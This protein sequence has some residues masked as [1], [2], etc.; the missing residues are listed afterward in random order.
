[1]IHR[2]SAFRDTHW[3]CSPATRNLTRQRKRVGLGGVGIFRHH[4][5]EFAD[6]CPNVAYAQS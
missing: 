4:L 2:T 1:M 6:T 3:H 5:R